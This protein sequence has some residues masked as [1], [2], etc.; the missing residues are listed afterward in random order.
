MRVSAKEP[1]LTRQIVGI[2]INAF[3]IA[4]AV[5]GGTLAYHAITSVMDLIRLTR[6]HT[7]PAGLAGEAIA[8]VGM[9]NVKARP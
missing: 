4:T 1:S 7:K 6:D 8:A 9:L 5:C 3:G 2:L